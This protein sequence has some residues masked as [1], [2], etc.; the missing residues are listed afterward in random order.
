MAQTLCKKTPPKR[1]T[2]FPNGILTK[3]LTAYAVREHRVAIFFLRLLQ[4]HVAITVATQA[5]LGG[6]RGLKVSCY[7]ESNPRTSS[8]PRKR[9]TF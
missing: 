8:L 9:S 1:W 2:A 3:S 7:R 5:I 4:F 6:F